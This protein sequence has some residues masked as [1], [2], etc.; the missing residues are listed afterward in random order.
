MPVQMGGVVLMRALP[1]GV[2][3][4]CSG[5]VGSGSPTR[6][7]VNSGIYDVSRSYRLTVCTDMNGK[8]CSHFWHFGHQ[9]VDRPFWV[10]RFTTPLH[11]AV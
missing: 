4:A 8:R 3:N 9:N 2:S 11:P 6:T 7:C 10:K 5:E 1:F